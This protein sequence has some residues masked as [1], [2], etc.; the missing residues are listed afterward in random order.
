MISHAVRE[1]RYV[2]NVWNSSA[3][4]VGGFPFDTKNFDQFLKCVEIPGNV[5]KFL[6]ETGSGVSET[7]SYVIRMKR[8]FPCDTLKNFD[9]F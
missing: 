7:E 2:W 1:I 9:P 8:G 5:I 4:C 6:E 3:C